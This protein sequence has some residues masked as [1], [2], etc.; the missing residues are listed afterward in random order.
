MWPTQLAFRTLLGLGAS[1]ESS[2]KSI[3]SPRG[4]MSIGDLMGADANDAAAPI[5]LPHDPRAAAP[6]HKSTSTRPTTTAE[7]SS[8]L[9]INMTAIK[10]QSTWPPFFSAKSPLNYCGDS[11]ER[12]DPEAVTTGPLVADCAALKGIVDY[13]PGYWDVTANA[14]GD[15]YMLV[16]SH[17][18]CGFVVKP[19]NTA[20]DLL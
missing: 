11:T 13:L 20:A 17:L 3:L 4:D 10:V 15:G 9:D 8:K 2:Q 6:A 1:H 18:T 12:P 19:W 16:T 5:L 7:T 14:G